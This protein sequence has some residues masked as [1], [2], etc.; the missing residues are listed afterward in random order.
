M[1]ISNSQDQ[2]RYLTTFYDLIS[3]YEEIAANRMKRTREKVLFNR[4][5]MY[6]LNN[7]YVQLRY[8][9]KR[10][11][12]NYKKRIIDKKNGKMIRVLVSSNSGLYGDLM[13]R[14]FNLFKNDYLLEPSDILVIGKTGKLFVDA[15]FL[16]T[17]YSYFD[18]S[19]SNFDQTIVS[20]IAAQ[21]HPYS[22]ILVYH[23]LFRNIVRQETVATNI[24]GDQLN[25]EALTSEPVKTYFEPSLPA[26]IDFF[27]KEIYKGLFSQTVYESQLAKFSSRMTALDQ[28]SQNLEKESKRLTTLYNLEKHQQ[29]NK[30]Q[31]SAIGRFFYQDH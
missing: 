26:L 30:K 2:L 28:A 5:Y 21:I 23:G 25:P 9:Y 1:K 13:I 10:M 19:D 20:K 6:G 14:V 31:Q 24:S 3:A 15:N 22:R 27:D 7:I 16:N 4:D 18:M 29:M 8:S 11:M 12:E 17:G